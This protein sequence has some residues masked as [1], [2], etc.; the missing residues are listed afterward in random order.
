MHFP[1]APLLL[2]ATVISATP[3]PTKRDSSTITSVFT[4]TSRALDR[5]TS[6][7]NTIARASPSTANAARYQQ[8]IEASAEDVS[9]IMSSG[10][11]RI[12]TIKP[13]SLVEGTAVGV[14]AGSL[15]GVQR[16]TTRAWMAAR[17]TIV[18]MRGGR[19]AALRML[20]GH[21]RASQEL[22]DAVTS[23]LPVLGKPLA[24]FL[25]KDARDEIKQAINAYMR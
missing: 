5:L 14:A 16:Q 6:A 24:G 4:D 20:R 13:L 22:I 1:I 9:R 7:L 3:P 18:G 8:D 12:R 17:S 10:A 19:E 2:L 11:R 23:K 25:G 21:E 15:E